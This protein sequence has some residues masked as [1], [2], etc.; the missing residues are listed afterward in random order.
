MKVYEI[1][2]EAPD[3]AEQQ[4]DY[5]PSGGDTATGAAVVGAATFGAIKAGGAV[6]KAMQGL[7]QK[8]RLTPRD[9]KAKRRLMQ[10]AQTRASNSYGNV[11]IS[12]LRLL[13]I[14]DPVYQLHAELVDAEEQFKTKNKAAKAS[15]EELNASEAELNEYKKQAWGVFTAQIL[16]RYIGRIA[17]NFIRGLK[18]I[19]GA[20]NV[21]G[22]LAAPLTGGLSVIAAVATEAAL[23]WAIHWLGTEKGRNWLADKLGSI[24]PLGGSI[25]ALLWNEITSF[26][27]GSQAGAAG[28]GGAA[29]KSAAPV[30][31]IKYIHGIQV[32][33]ASGNILPLVLN[34]ARLKTYLGAQ[35]DLQGLGTEDQIKAELAKQQPVK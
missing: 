8:Y 6:S 20:K 32:T 17:I 1:I 18:I 11:G 28:A 27:R 9:L 23:L 35:K 26:F 33:D 30:S 12:F 5:S 14:L 3:N 21:A 15:E 29:T 22:A 2:L 24:L 10:I 31:K 25:P 7:R 13:Q 16:T 4:P 34:N 19:K